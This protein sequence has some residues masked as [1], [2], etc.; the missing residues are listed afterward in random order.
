MTNVYKIELCVIDHDDIGAESIK[1][2]LEN[3][4]Y[5]TPSVVT[6][7]EKDIG[8]WYDEHPLNYSNT[9]KQ[10]LARLFDKW[11]P[12]ETAP[13]NLYVL[14]WHPNYGVTEAIFDPEEVYVGSRVLDH[15]WVGYYCEDHWYTFVL[16]PAPLYWQ[17]KPEPPQL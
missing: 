4:R 6:I 5:A 17:Y 3:T 10:E 12:I 1:E 2:L 14:V 15:V 16:D 11:Q 7:E 13:S 9:Q 8:E